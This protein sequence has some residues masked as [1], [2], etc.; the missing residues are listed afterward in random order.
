MKSL[1]VIDGRAP[2]FVELA[3]RSSL[4]FA[5]KMLGWVLAASANA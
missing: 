1:Y 4:S 3:W 5:S 2:I